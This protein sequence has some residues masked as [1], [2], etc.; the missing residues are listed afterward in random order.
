MECLPNYDYW[1]TTPP[2]DP[3]P[4]NYCNSCG[5]ALYEGD[6]LYKIDGGICEEC[7]EEYYEVML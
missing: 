4:V 5:A 1:K 7:L 2:D 6:K 3:E